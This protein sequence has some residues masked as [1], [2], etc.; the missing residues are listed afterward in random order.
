MH[1]YVFLFILTKSRHVNKKAFQS[2]ANCQL[3]SKFEKVKGEGAGGSQVN[4]LNHI[5]GGQAGVVP[6]WVG[7][8]PGYPGALV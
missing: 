8:R 1:R 4:K 7:D 2:K 5:Y 6:I 3:V